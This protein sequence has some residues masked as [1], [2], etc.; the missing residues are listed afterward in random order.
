VSFN[1]T[2]KLAEKLRQRGVEI[3]A[4]VL[5]EVHSFLRQAAAQRLPGPGSSSAG[6]LR[7]RR[8]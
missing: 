4:I 1:E 8:R 7:R 5:D 2:V 3:K 6:S